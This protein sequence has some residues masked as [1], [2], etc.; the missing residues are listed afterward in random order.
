MSFFFFNNE[1]RFS[2]L[3]RI[4]FSLPFPPSNRKST[5]VSDLLQSFSDR[6]KDRLSEVFQSCFGVSF[7]LIAFLIGLGFVSAFFFNK[8]GL[9]DSLF[10]VSFNALLCIF[11]QF[12]SKK[13]LFHKQKPF[14][15]RPVQYMFFHCLAYSSEIEN[16]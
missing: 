13:T 15:I 5:F 9:S 12:G 11:F 14:R 2:D 16:F 6:R 7:S 4:C 10:F 8:N 3:F 1:K